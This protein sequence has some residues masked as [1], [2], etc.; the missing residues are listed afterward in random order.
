MKKHFK[1]AFYY[2]AKLVI[3]F[4]IGSFFVVSCN[5]NPLADREPSWLGASIY[6]YLKTDGHFTNYVKLIDD[7]D[8]KEVLAKTGS[9]TLFVANDS[10]FN[11]FYK[12]NDWNVN[13]YNQ[14]S[15]A[16]KKLILNFGMI[17]D[18]YLVEMLSNYNS[19]ALVEGGAMRKVTAVSVLDSLPYENGSTLPAG[20][21]W[22]NY[23]MKGIYLLKD[24]TLWTT[25]YFTQKQLDQAQITDQDFKLLTGLTREHNDAHVFADKIIKRDITSKN[26]YLNVLQSVLIPPSNMAQFVN[27]NPNMS[28]FTSL[29]ERFSAPYF[30][31]SNTL[32]YRQL[33]PLFTD[34]IFIKRYFSQLGGTVRYPNGQSI[35]TDLLLPFDPGWNSY[36][37]NVVGSALE[38]DMAAM[39]VPNN[40]A[41]NQFFNSGAGAVLK[42]RFGSWDNVPTSILPLFLKRHMRTSLIQ[43]VPSRFSN[44]VDGDNSKLPVSQS[45]IQNVYIGKNGVVYET[46]KV[47]APDD[48]SSVYGPVL[49]SA[50]DAS[51]TNKTKV[52]NWAIVQNDFRLYLNSMVSKYSFFVPTDDYFTQYIDPIAYAKNVPA[53]LKYWYNNKTSAVNATVYKFNIAT[54]QVGDSI[55][56]ITS[57]SFLS[58]RLLD[59]LNM[60]IVVGGVET[61][62]SY[63]LTKGN[64]AIKVSGSG[65][66]MTIQG[67]ENI[68]LNNPVK[69]N[70]VYNQ[71]NGYTY[72]IDKPIQSPLT[73]V[74]SILSQQPQF[75]A[76][77]ALLSGFPATSNSIIFV[78]KTN[79][80][81]IDFNVK[82]FNTFNYTV[83][84]PTNDAINK[85]IQAGIII[86]WESQGSIVGINDMT[87]ATVQAAAI[88]TLERFLRYH[89]QD[90]SVFLDGQPVNTTYQS[91]TIKLDNLPT[92]FGTF[93][94]KYY[95]IGVSGTGSDLTLTTE[96]NQ[97]AHVVTSSGLYNIMT[98]DFVFSNKLSA[99]KDIDGTGTGADF[100]NSS[101]YTSSTAVIHQIDAVLN[102]Q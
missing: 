17:N 92:N 48:Y 21:Y 24:N 26:G 68:T 53:A 41:M 100:S 45:D 83:Y 34:S 78:N 85:A 40:D 43:S 6:D 62:K 90:N 22:D 23:R 10:A 81:G 99:Y 8:Y 5:D 51:P 44:M 9:K 60:H 18:A 39:F 97:T 36:S 96:T 20:T 66:D 61:G 50:N 73:S 77:F 82:F 29:L 95:K 37:N 3:V 25:M 28:I 35:N 52:W 86:P 38:S 13:A 56:V 70:R 7:L 46:S 19:G 55:A 16:Q 47:Y 14:L 89:F 69:V 76:F 11:E 27:A 84:V 72:F 42:D 75:S 94:N 15:F 63:Y 88:S 54:G 30:D 64:V 57:T 32:L 87:D 74:F 98:R 65:T 71:S 80:Y 102:F 59:L 58:N 4:A 79:Y 49:L 12:K 67:G 91:A 93:Q 1:G 31:P 33:N 2:Y 101:I